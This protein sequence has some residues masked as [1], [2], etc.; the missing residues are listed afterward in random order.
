[1]GHWDRPPAV[2]KQVKLMRATPQN[3]RDLMHT[4][5]T[6]TLDPTSTLLNPFW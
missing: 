1:M 3:P 6:H 5:Y 2:V 4:Q